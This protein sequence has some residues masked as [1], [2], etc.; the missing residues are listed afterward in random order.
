MLKTHE[1]ILNLLALNETHHLKFYKK[2]Q[3]IFNKLKKFSLLI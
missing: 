3:I 2:K 1:K